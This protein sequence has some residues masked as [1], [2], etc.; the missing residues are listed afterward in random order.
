M[1]MYCVWRRVRQ[2]KWDAPSLLR[3]SN[4]KFCFCVLC[5]EVISTLAETACHTMAHLGK[6]RWQLVLFALWGK[7]IK[8][9]KCALS[10]WKVNL[11]HQRWVQEFW[12]LRSSRSSKPK[13]QQECPAEEQSNKDRH[14]I[15][16]ELVFDRL[17]WSVISHRTAAPHWMRCY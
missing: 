10:L 8:H 6:V 5:F 13:E 3:Q 16:C 2:L 14:C 1:Q 4:Y 12:E 9:V 7:Q 15:I 17:K 11:R